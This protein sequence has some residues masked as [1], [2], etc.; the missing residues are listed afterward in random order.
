MALTALLQQG[1]GAKLTDHTP[2]QPLLELQG[3]PAKVN[4]A[5]LEREELLLTQL[6]PGYV[7]GVPMNRCGV[8]RGHGSTLRGTGA[9]VKNPGWGLLHALQIRLTLSRCRDAPLSGGLCTCIWNGIRIERWLV[10]MYIRYN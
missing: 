3:S 5:T 7:Q 8:R 9:S 2:G 1:F 10:H 6:I 4:Q